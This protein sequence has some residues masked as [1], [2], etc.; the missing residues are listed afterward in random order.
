MT[1][2]IQ[3]FKQ[4]QNAF[5]IISGQAEK[6]TPEDLRNQMKIISE[7]IFELEA[8]IAS[9]NAVGE[10][11]E[12]LD[13]LFTAYGLVQKAEELVK[14][15]KAKGVDTDKAMRIIAKANL[16]KFPSIYKEAEESKE[17]YKTK[18]IEVKISHNET[19]DVYVLMDENNKVRKSVDFI[20]ADLI[21][22]VPDYL[23]C[24]K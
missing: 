13:V 9:G 18:G 7:E 16:S 21:S 1:Y 23:K 17:F 5:N 2:T 8:D 20:K 24:S 12:T 3:E 4:D 6:V 11:G 10:V 22:C 14:R 19:Y 15:L